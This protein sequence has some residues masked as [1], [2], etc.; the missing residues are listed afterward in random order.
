MLRSRNEWN[1]GRKVKPFHSI[2]LNEWNWW[3]WFHFFSS[4]AALSF[5]S[6]E[7]ISLKRRRARQEESGWL[8]W[9]VSGL[10]AGGSSAASELH[11]RAASFSSISSL[12]P[13]LLPFKEKTSSRNAKENEMNFWWRL[14]GMAQLKKTKPISLLRILLNECARRRRDCL[15]CLPAAPSINSNE[16]LSLNCGA[17]RPAEQPT[18]FLLSSAKTKSCLWWRRERSC[19]GAVVAGGA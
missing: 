9:E 7:I 14:K 3:N 2:L 11:S 19:C 1:K 4:P 8:E 13:I 18:L 16:N 17:A 10:W 12:L 15:F 5:F 6:N